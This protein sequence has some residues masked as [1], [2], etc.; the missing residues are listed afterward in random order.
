MPIQG[1]ATARAVTHAY[2]FLDQTPPQKIAS[3]SLNFAR[4]IWYFTVFV[5]TM[6]LKD[7]LIA[8]RTENK[9][10]QNEGDLYLMGK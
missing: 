10:L 2:R 5:K 3:L 8:L 6:I 1:M 4:R 9:K 7:S